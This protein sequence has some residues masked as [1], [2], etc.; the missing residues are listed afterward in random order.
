MKL[1]VFCPAVG[2]VLGVLCIGSSC[3]VG[4][5]REL[6]AFSRS[7]QQLAKE[8]PM[9]KNVPVAAPDPYVLTEREEKRFE[10]FKEHAG[11]LFLMKKTK[12]DAMKKLLMKYFCMAQEDLRRVLLNDVADIEDWIKSG[13]GASLEFWPGQILLQMAFN[14][15]REFRAMNGFIFD[16]HA[17][18]AS[19]ARSE[20]LLSKLNKAA[21]DP[22]FESVLAV[23]IPEEKK[24]L[25]EHY[26]IH[27]M[28]ADESETARACAVIHGLQSDKKQQFGKACQ[29]WKVS[30]SFRSEKSSDG[31]ALPVIVVY[32]SGKDNATIVLNGLLKALK[33]IKGSGLW[34]THN[35]KV[36][37]LIFYAQGD[38]DFKTNPRMEKLF[39]KENGHLA[40]YKPDFTGVIQDYH[41]PII[42]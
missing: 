34:P 41:L 18:D 16:K 12:S 11:Y 5:E 7:L 20:K 36:N 25:V 19:R 23:L 24:N 42:S 38:R 40:L 29:D 21:L 31:D 35:I 13:H 10:V 30:W 4:C 6:Q 3:A 17:Q 8:I 33:G 22:D 28:P 1:A 27:V 15:S 26:K 2:L 37:D 9:E 14:E 32:V 39:E